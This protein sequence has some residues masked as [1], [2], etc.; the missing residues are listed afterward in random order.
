MKP[1]GDAWFGRLAWT[2]GLFLWSA[3]TAAA[4]PSV[5]LR[6][7]AFASASFANFGNVVLPATGYDSLEI[8]LRD[9]LAQ[10]QTSTVRV[11]LNNMPMTPF[12]AIH[13]VPGGVRVV[14]NL[15]V[16]LSPD[17]AIK[18]EGESIL[19]FAASDI[20]GT[21]YRGQFYLAIDPDKTSPEPARSTRARSQE[22]TTIAPAQYRAPA[23]AITSKEI[24][25]TA[26][27]VYWLEAKVTDVEGLRKVVI[28]LN[29]RDVE[30]VV[31]QNERP[32]RYK[33]GRISRATGAGEVAGDGQTVRLRVP[34]TLAKDRINVI[35]L[36]AEN[37]HGLSTR[38]DRTVEV[39]K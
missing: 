34:L 14:I 8:V 13:P 38:A 7:P 12:V 37:L 35:A 1:R 36:R 11:T 31:L 25:R 15:G 3:A 20:G 33:D 2:L 22:A 39:F 26:D 30:E 27:R 9:A 6:V 16:S 28:E 24:G 19:T 10:V 32:I 29:G 21:A 23:I 17:Y 4:E 5:T 18:R